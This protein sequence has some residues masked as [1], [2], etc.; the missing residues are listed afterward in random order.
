MKQHPAKK[1]LWLT[2]HSWIHRF[3][4]L[5]QVSAGGAPW[6]VPTTKYHQ[7]WYQLL[8][9][10]RAHHLDTVWDPGGGVHRSGSRCLQPACRWVHAP[11][12]WDLNHSLSFFLSYFCELFS[13]KV[14]LQLTRWKLGQED[15]SWLETVFLEQAGPEQTLYSFHKLQ[16]PADVNPVHSELL[17]QLFL[18]LFSW[19][20]AINFDSTRSLGK[21][22]CRH[23]WL[24]I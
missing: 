11:G 9:H 12:R 7:P 24:V 4:P 20:V 5:L 13:F 22:Y 1:S 3:S 6:R 16:T 8:P 18:G 23:I 21:I 19:S 10:H 2:A 17:H 15:K 14:N